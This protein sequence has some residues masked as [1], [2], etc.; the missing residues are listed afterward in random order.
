MRAFSRIAALALALALPVTPVAAEEI[1]EQAVMAMVERAV[2][3]LTRDG[4][5]ALAVIGEKDGAFHDGALYAFVY[6]ENVVML[7]HPVKPSL[8][9]K[10]YRGKPDIRGKR[11]RDEIVANA[12][13]GGGWTEYVYQKPGVP[14]LFHKK[15]Y[16]RLAEH[17][18]KRYVV[19]S[20]MYVGK[21]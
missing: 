15:V 12:L 5:A 11:F 21:L 3:L 2:A 18:G 19:A 13:N 6:D 17:A 1:D 4:D 8:V 10:S 16:S 9:G 20:G 7:A 14:G